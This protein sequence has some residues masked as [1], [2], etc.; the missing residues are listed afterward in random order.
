MA[1]PAQPAPLRKQL[2]NRLA[3]LKSMRAGGVSRLLQM[4]EQ[5]KS[6]EEF[7]ASTD[8]ATLEVQR[9]LSLLPPEPAT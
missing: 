3:E 9:T 7:V 6:Q 5:V 1:D 8:G 4:R 2:E